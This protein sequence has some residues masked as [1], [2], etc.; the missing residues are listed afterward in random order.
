[1]EE[2]VRSA[3]S[4]RGA[5]KQMAKEVGLPL[6]KFNQAF[7]IA[8]RAA[9]AAPA[10]DAQEA[11]RRKLAIWAANGGRET[12]ISKPAT[13]PM[14]QLMNAAAT[15][16]ALQTTPPDAPIE[17]PAPA[18]VEKAAEAAKKITI[19]DVDKAMEAA[20][21]RWQA[22]RKPGPMPM[23]KVFA[24]RARQLGWVEDVEFV[25]ENA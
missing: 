5:R 14:L 7:D 4:Y 18:T 16:H 21:T 1:M 20:L 13:D 23:S 8:A 19:A 12:A 9:E 6:S 24:A 17:A 2:G 25:E 11:A 3:S 15:R 22:D 10:G